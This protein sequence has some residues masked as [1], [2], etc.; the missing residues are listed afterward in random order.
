MTSPSGKE[1]LPRE[2]SSARLPAAR[3]TIRAGLELT[4]TQP[5]PARADDLSAVLELVAACGLPTAGVRDQFPGA[6]AVLRSETGLAAVAG[7]EVYGEVGLLRSVAVQPPLRGC[8]L[9]EALLAD[10]LRAAKAQ[11]LRAVYLLTTTAADYFRRLGFVDAA[12]ADAPELQG[13][14]EF[15]SIC[16]STAV[17]LSKTLR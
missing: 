8:G 4:C 16:P 11:N 5:A 17:C 12:R 6:Y 9:G 2:K 1:P 10:R 3:D 13:C 7:L 14:A 15:A